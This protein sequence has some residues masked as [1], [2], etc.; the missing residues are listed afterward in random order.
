MLN[1]KE[2]LKLVEEGRGIPYPYPPTHLFLHLT[3]IG[4]N[5]LKPLR[6]LVVSLD[7]MH[8]SPGLP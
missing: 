8:L 4:R 5:E 1:C 2:K 6:W 7:I 3:P